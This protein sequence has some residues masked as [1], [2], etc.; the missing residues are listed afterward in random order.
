[1]VQDYGSLVDLLGMLA[2][3]SLKTSYW[4]VLVTRPVP[5]VGQNPMFS[6]H[7]G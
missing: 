2:N 6:Y 4:Q 5:K 7:W 3:P 1:M